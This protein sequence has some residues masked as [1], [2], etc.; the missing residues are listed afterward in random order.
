MPVDDVHT[1][2]ASPVFRTVNRVM[3]ICGQLR[4]PRFAVPADRGHPGHTMPALPLPPD[5]DA[6]T[7]ASATVR[8]LA[9]VRG[10]SVEELA[11]VC[12]IGRT[13][14]FTRLNAKAPWKLNEIVAVADYLDKPLEW[15]LTGNVSLRPP[16]GT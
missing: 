16:T 14:M 7:I 4:V 10:I 1:S 8:G 15:L 2:D 9:Y 13:A 3:R 12:G 6:N 5:A 11:Q